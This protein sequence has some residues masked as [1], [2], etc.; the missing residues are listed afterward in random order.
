MPVVSANIKFTQGPNTDVAGRAVLG[1]LTDG[2]ITVENGDNTNVDFWEFELLFVP[3]DSAIPVGVKSSGASSSIVIPQPD[4][5][6]CYRFRLEVRDAGAT[7]VDTDIRNF[8]VP[9]E[10]GWVI[11]PYQ[12]DIFL[13]PDELNFNGQPFGWAGD[14]QTG[15]L[16]TIIRNLGIVFSGP[17]KGAA[18]LA[19]AGTNHDVI[20]GGIQS[21]DGTLT[22]PSD[23]VLLKDQTNPTENGLYITSSTGSWV[24][25]T[26]ADRNGVFPP[27]LTVYVREGAVNT[28]TYWTLT[29]LAVDLG[30]TPLVF[31]ELVGA[32]THVAA[33]TSDDKDL[34]VSAP[35]PYADNVATGLT[36][37][38]QPVG[39]RYVTVHVNGSSVTV[40]DGVK[41]KACYFSSDS[42]VTAKNFI[43]IVP[44]DELIWNSII[45]N[46]QL[47]TADSIDFDYDVVAPS[48]VVP[49]VPYHASTHFKSG[50]DPIVAQNLGSGALA[51]GQI[52]ESDGAGGWI[53]IPTPGGG[54]IDHGTLIGLLDDDHGQYH[55]NSRGDARYFRKTEFLNSSSGAGDAGKPIILD[56][57]GMV[58][59]TMIDDGDI[60]HLNIANIGVN[61]HA[62]VDT[63]IADLTLH[64]A[65]ASIDHGVLAGLGDNDHPQY[66]L[67]SD[68]GI[69]N[70]YAGL[71]A[72]VKLLGTQMPYGATINTV[73]EGNDSRLS[74]D[75]TASGIRTATSI[76]VVN[77]AAAPTVGQAL[78]ATS[79]TAATWQDPHG[80]LGG[81][82]L[83]TAATTSVAGFMSAADKT[84]L[85][86][87][88][89]YPRQIC[90]PLVSDGANPFVAITTGSYATLCYLPF[91]GSSLLGTPTAIYVLVWA[92]TATPTPNF[93]VRLYDS[94]NSL[95]I[96]EA[97]NITTSLTPVYLPL[98]AIS[99]VPSSDAILVIQ[100]RANSNAGRLAF[101]N[102]RF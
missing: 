23:L 88:A 20:V 76:V 68:K 61:S 14:N 7:F 2:T 35:T 6:G 55:N 97:L 81:G 80:N 16:E 15:L 78:R 65:Q 10:R 37:T 17:W 33:P 100:G 5:P 34:N 99:N 51:S 57:N 95:V 73:C 92:N 26:G 41:T 79:P 90:I 47:S 32:G 48:S 87:M 18:R 19:S 58:D 22:G 28:Q 89:S 66:Q 31:Q 67:L 74:D 56:A 21:V 64:Y 59:A 75:R 45:S 12:G 40:G 54:T 70:G 49:V 96:A 42:G 13:D 93:D 9:D 1:T 101:F 60:D 44:G 98:G 52:L 94:T 63:H 3:P 24:R 71:D 29:T 62:Q 30:T 43:N 38:G 4:V 84:A 27:G 39:H 83:H 91:R 46:Y 86:A 72:S 53:T 82:L 50:V 69:A 8:A 36:I 25:A 85:D 11:P 77:T 102:M